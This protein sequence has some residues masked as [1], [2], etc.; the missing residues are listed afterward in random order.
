MIDGGPRS[1]SVTAIRD[2]RLDFVTRAA[3]EAFAQASPEVYRHIAV[4]LARHLRGN[5][6]ALVAMS[7]LSVKGRAARA[8][9]SLADA[10]GEDVGAGRLLMHQKVTQG[11]LAAM[12]GIA[13]ENLSRIL[14][15]WM[16]NALIKRL[17]TSD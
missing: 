9:L 15:E 17:P 4:L 10:F 13:R 16:R 8:L 14:Q 12:A 5:N 6:A 1:A 7:F 11:E 3:F 2:A